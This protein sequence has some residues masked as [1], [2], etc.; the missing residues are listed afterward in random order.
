MHGHISALQAAWCRCCEVGVVSKVGMVVSN[1]T[2]VG[3]RCGKWPAVAGLLSAVPQALAGGRVVLHEPA[4]HSVPPEAL[5]A[6]EPLLSQVPLLAEGGQ[7][8]AR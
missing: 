3:G 7:L 2:S 8:L 5:G 1:H 4:L 6:S